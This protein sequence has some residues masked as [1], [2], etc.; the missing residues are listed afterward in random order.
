MK[1]TMA[2]CEVFPAGA[3]TGL[4]RPVIFVLRYPPATQ[5]LL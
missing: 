1:G 4:V 2:A 5:K 3:Q